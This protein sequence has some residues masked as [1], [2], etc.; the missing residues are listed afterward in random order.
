[1][2]TYTVR[3]VADAARSSANSMVRFVDDVENPWRKT[4]V[5]GCMTISALH[6][7]YIVNYTR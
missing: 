7:F 2:D 3:I 6:R 5:F 1:M 4:L